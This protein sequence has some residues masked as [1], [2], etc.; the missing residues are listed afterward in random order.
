MKNQEPSTKKVGLVTNLLCATTERNLEI[1]F[2]EEEFLE[3]ITYNPEFG[4]EVLVYLINHL[5]E[6]YWSCCYIEGEEF[7]DILQPL[8]EDFLCKAKMLIESSK[9]NL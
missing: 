8:S 1:W 6:H 2:C 9:Y 7:C 4:D 3:S 5:N